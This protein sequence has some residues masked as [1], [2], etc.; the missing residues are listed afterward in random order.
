[1]LFYLIPFHPHPVL[2]YQ[3]SRGGFILPGKV[4]MCVCG[5]S[6]SPDSKGVPETLLCS[7]SLPEPF[8]SRFHPLAYIHIH[9]TG[10]YGTFGCLGTGGYR[11]RKKSGDR[12]LRSYHHILIIHL[13]VKYISNVLFRMYKY[14]STCG[15]LPVLSQAPPAKLSACRRLF[16]CDTECVFTCGEVCESVFI[17][18]AHKQPATVCVDTQKS[19]TTSSS[20][21]TT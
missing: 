17:R 13:H 4:G 10:R 5:L 21:D 6:Q 9:R 11:C 14:T 19:T 7:C 15:V 16:F 2:Y 1:M 3:L 8:S 18:A 20:D 12:L